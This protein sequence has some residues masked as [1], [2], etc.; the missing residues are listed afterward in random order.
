M[1]KL[2]LPD[3]GEES[4]ENELSVLIRRPQRS[5]SFDWWRRFDRSS[6]KAGRPVSLR[7]F[8]LEHTSA[9]EG[10]TLAWELTRVT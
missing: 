2:I 10:C 1:L 6:G 8:G 5:L 4:D 3:L 7:Y 9:A